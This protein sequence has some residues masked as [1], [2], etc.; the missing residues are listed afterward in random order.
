MIDDFDFDPG[1]A[2]ADEGV[3]DPDKVPYG[4]CVQEKWT[5]EEAAAAAVWADTELIGLIPVVFEGE[6][7]E[8][9]NAKEMASLMGLD[10]SPTIEEADAFV[11]QCEDVINNELH[12]LA[13]ANEKPPAPPPETI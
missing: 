6:E 12:R 8:L 1:P 2:D 3:P 11:S 5:P 7:G 4:L 9:L 10:R 13:L